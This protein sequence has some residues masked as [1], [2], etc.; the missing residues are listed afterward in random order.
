MAMAKSR[1]RLKHFLFGRPLP[2]ERLEHE[3]LNKKTALAV[4]S[5]DAISSVAYATDQ[6]LIVLAGLG[7]AAALQYAVPISGVIV[8]L[9]VLVGL[10]YRQ[11]I[12]AYP[13]GGGS[14][15]VAKENLGTGSGLVAA[16]ALLTDYIMT[17]AVSIAGGIA[18]ITS[19]Y[20]GLIAHTV[21]LC[22]ASIALLAIVNLR[23][24]RESGLA[25]SVPTYVF[26]A[27]MVILIVYGGYRALLGTGPADATGVVRTDPVSL[28]QH[29]TGGIATGFAISYLLIRGFAEG[30]AAMTGT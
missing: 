15:T 6:I 19:A 7:K 3:R 1:K 16:A 11:T 24:V 10:S 29:A 13:N 4:L 30:C 23:G 20:H 12:F 14:Y 28:Q 8:G 5:S 25:F 18:A 26:I 9:L 2:S 17:V 27:M 22:V 21:T